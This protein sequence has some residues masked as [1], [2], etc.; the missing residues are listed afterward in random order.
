MRRKKEILA[1]K[2]MIYCCSFF[3]LFNAI[4]LNRPFGG[5]IAF[6]MILTTWII[7]L[8][9]RDDMAF[10]IWSKRK[11]NKFKTNK[12]IE[13]PKVVIHKKISSGLEGL[14]DKFIYWLNN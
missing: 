5:F 11:I 8:W 9:W 2:I 12:P 6:V 1:L 13:I 14:W 4:D 3:L 7:S 10:Y